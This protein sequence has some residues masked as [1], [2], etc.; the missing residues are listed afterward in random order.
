MRQFSLQKRITSCLVTKKL[1]EQIENYLF[2]EVPKIIGISKEEITESYSLV[3]SDNFGEET[4]SS[5]SEYR[6]SLFS[7]STNK[8]YINLYTS[9]NFIFNIHFDKNQIYSDI[10]V[11]YRSDNPR[12]TIIGIYN[13]LKR[14]IDQNKNLNKILNPSPLSFMIKGFL[15]GIGITS[16]VICLRGILKKEDNLSI[17]IYGL[18]FAFSFFYVILSFFKPYISFESNRQRSIKKASDWFFWGF[19]SFIFFGV[20]FV[21]FRKNI[22]GF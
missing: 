11:E 17:F 6:L 8:I 1:L 4:F 13:N 19:L 5:I 2:E 10:H 21:L 14:I 22:L 7:D 15:F 20:I 9:E 3:I 16:L 18:I 12:D